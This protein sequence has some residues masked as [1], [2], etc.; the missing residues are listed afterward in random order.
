MTRIRLQTSTET[1]PEISLRGESA[2]DALIIL[3]RYLDDAML[4]G[5]QEVRIV[6]GKGEGILRRAVTEYL[7]RDKRV[8]SKRLGQWNEGADGV[9]IAKLRIES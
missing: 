7:S 2:E 8:E 6:H 3:D 1:G 5:W 9:T 4:A